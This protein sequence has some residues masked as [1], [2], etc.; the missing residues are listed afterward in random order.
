MKE[1]VTKPLQLKKNVN[2]NIKEGIRIE[3]NF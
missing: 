2:L 1:K 3:K